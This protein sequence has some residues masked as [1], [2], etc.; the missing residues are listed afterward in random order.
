M[1]DPTEH[2]T[3]QRIGAAIQAGALEEPFRA[4]DINRVLGVAWGGTFSLDTVKI[5]VGQAPGLF[6]SASASIDSEI[7]TPQTLSFGFPIHR[8]LS[9]IACLMRRHVGR[10]CLSGEPVGFELDAVT[11]E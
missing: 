8:E 5:Q 2:E 9:G 7:R 6:A 3:M 11:Q 1:I 10:G 4:C